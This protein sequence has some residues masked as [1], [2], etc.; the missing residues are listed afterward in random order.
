[1]GRELA[2]AA[3]RGVDVRIIIPKIPDKKMVYQVTC[4]Y[5]GDLTKCGV[6]V[7]KYTPGF[8]HSK[9]CLVDDRA[10]IVGTIN[11]DYRSLFHHFE[12]ACLFYRV[13]AVKDVRRDFEE[14]FPECE[15]V[16]EIYCKRSTALRTW[17]CVLRFIA[18]LL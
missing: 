10:A 8:C 2:L 16:T 7:Y 17:E 12:D 6:R 9:V 18:P 1:M 13:R 5:L 14:T 4:S 3:K 11:F 15:E